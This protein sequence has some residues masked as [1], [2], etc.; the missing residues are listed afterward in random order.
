[1]TTKTIIEEMSCKKEELPQKSL[2]KA[3]E[4]LKTTHDVQAH[5]KNMVVTGVHI[6]GDDDSATVTLDFESLALVSS[7]PTERL[8]QAFIKAT[9]AVLRKLKEEAKAAN[10]EESHD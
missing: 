4:L 9:E 2:E 6:N 5:I 7:D 1:M 10:K 8:R 3:F